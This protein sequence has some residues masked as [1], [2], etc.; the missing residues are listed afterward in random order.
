VLLP[1]SPRTKG[2]CCPT[3]GST[4]PVSLAAHP[5]RSTSQETGDEFLKYLPGR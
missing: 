1:M 3:F 2:V 5:V 4:G